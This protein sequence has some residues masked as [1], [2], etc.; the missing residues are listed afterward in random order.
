MYKERTKTGAKAYQR[1]DTENRVKP[2]SDWHRTLHGSLLM[3]DVDFVEWRYKNGELVPVGVMEITR[4]DGDK[5][6]GNNYLNAI[7]NRFEK[8]DV[9]AQAARKVAGALG[10]KAYIVLF[11]QDCSEFWVYCL[12]N[13]D[14]WSHFSPTEMESFLVRLR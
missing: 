3:L 10:T 13:P 7:I 5:P 14:G 11:R 9:Q 4:V 8:R 2:Y 1:S 12:S 6:V